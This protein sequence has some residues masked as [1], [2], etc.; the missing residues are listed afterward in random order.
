MPGRPRCELAQLFFPN[1]GIMSNLLAYKG[2]L[3]LDY[4]IDAG[5]ILDRSVAGYF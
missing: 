4:A 2:S 1:H 3:D 5:M